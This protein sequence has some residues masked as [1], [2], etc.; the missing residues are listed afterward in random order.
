M[1]QLVKLQVHIEEPQQTIIETYEAEEWDDFK[2]IL[3]PS[4]FTMEQVDQLR[5]ELQKTHT[6]KQFILLPDHLRDSIHVLYKA[7]HTCTCR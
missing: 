3:L 2:I 7:I 6:G 1:N 4:N 5:A